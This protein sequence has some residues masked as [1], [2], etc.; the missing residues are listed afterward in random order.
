MR[1]MSLEE[2]DLVGHRGSGSEERTSSRRRLCISGCEQSMQ[3]AKVRA[4]AVVSWPAIRKVINWLTRPSSVNPPDSIA[5]DRMFRV[6]LSFARSSFDF[7]CRTR[8]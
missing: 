5:T 2:M 7:S 6:G 8:E 4:E 3:I 1:S